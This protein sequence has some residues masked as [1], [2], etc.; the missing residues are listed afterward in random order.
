M[1]ILKEIKEVKNVHQKVNSPS[2]ETGCCVRSSVKC[3]HSSPCSSWPKESCSTLGFPFFP[4]RSFKIIYRNPDHKPIWCY[5]KEIKYIF[6]C[7]LTNFCRDAMKTAKK[8]WWHYN[9]NNN[10]N[11]LRDKQTFLRAVGRLTLGISLSFPLLT[12]GAVESRALCGA[13]Y[14]CWCPLNMDGT[15]VDPELWNGVVVPTKNT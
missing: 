6:L 14:S 9:S 2:W 7:V 3:R 10:N 15:L 12:R 11:N 8:K 4:S 5:L 1:Y 13:E